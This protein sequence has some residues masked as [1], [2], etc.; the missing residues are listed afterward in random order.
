MLRKLTALL[1]AL[2]LIMLWGVYS[3]PEFIEKLVGIAG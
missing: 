1:L 3:N 2:T